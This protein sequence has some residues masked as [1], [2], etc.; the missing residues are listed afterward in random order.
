MAFEGLVQSLLSKKE[1]FRQQ[2]ITRID[3]ETGQYSELLGTEQKDLCPSPSELENLL[4]VKQNLE[5]N[6]LRLNRNLEPTQQTV[7]TIQSTTGAVNSIIRTVKAL[8]IP[9]K[10]VTIGITATFSDI[11]DNTKEFL[12]ELNAE[13]G[14]LNYTISNTQDAFLEVASKLNDIETILNLCSTEQ[15]STSEFQNFITTLNQ[16]RNQ[17]PLSEEYKGYR[18]E[19]KND[20]DSPTIAPRRFAVAIAPTGAVVYKGPPSFSSSTK[21]LIEE[22]KFYIDQ[23]TR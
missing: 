22:V 2:A 6:I 15:S 4:R 12:K 3:Q 21:I 16:E 1:V 10:W 20:P 14:N 17:N 23:L 13:A 8:P 7:Q 19:I 11:L 5:E 9:A 18:I